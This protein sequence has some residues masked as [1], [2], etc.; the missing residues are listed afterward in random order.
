LQRSDCVTV[1]NVFDYLNMLYPTDTACSFDNVGLLV[2]DSKAEVFKA[3]VCLDC[4]ADAL[5]F[6]KD[7][8]CN[9][10]ITH[11]PVI[12]SPL[13]SILADSV[14]Y[15]LIKSGISVI[16]MHTNLDMG[17]G[18]V[19]DCLCNALEL[20][21]ILPLT[22]DDG[23]VLKQGN[24]SS[25]SAEDFAK[26]IKLALGGRVKYVDGGKAIEKVLVCSGSGGDFIGEAIKGGF[27]ALVTSD[28]KHHL[29]LTAKENGIS[30][31]DAGHFET[32]DI[33]IEPLRESLTA[34]FQ[35]TEFIT[36]HSTDFKYV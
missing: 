27:D 2:G 22:V 15:E 25:L 18:G 34:H 36:Y 9:L 4:T 35:T 16:S 28:I 14:V 1:Q 24:I 11:H 21:N 19:N 26:K 30:L 29:F 8:G 33:C 7:K 20:N 13:K 5:A 10:I 23:F 3:L 17:D 6:A 31:F 32:E 12:F